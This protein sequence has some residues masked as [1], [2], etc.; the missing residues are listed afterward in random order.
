MILWQQLNLTEAKR[1]ALEE[2]QSQLH[3]D[4]NVEQVIL[5]GSVVRGELDE[6]S[7]IDLLD[8]VKNPI[9]R[10]QRHEITDRVCEINLKYGTNLSTTVVHRE[11]WENGPM[12]LLPIYEHVRREGIPL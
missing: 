1:L 11:A 12:R 10:W 9:N 7:D 4:K 8:I 5:F 3:R 2:A 6:E